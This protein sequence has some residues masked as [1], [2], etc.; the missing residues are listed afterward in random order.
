MEHAKVIRSIIVAVFITALVVST[1]FLAAGA[2]NDYLGPEEKGP[3]AT[4]T[5]VAIATDGLGGTDEHL[6]VPATW[7]SGGEYDIGVRVVGLRSET[8]VLTKFSLTRPGISNEDVSVFYYDTIS[9]SWRTLA[10]QDQGDS[11]V[12][13]LGL[14]GGIAMYEGYDFLHR[15]II[16]SYIE[17]ECQV[18][19]WVEVV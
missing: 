1:A 2:L 18:R 7:T 12:A 17:G 10:L 8:G 5:L 11:L 9:S 14:T 16:H 19:A 4:V 6:P 13:T 3:A 15:L